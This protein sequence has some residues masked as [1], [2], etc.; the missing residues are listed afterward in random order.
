MDSIDALIAARVVKPSG[1]VSGEAAVWNGSGWDRSSVTRLGATS[2]GSGTP[3]ATKFLRGDGS[4]QVVSSGPTI[5]Y[6]TTP[7]GSPATGDIWIAVDSTTAPTYQWQFRWNGASTNADKWEFIGG[8]GK[9][10]R[11]D[12]SENTASGTDVDLTTVGP[13]F[14]LPRAGVYQ[15][16]WGFLAGLAGGGNATSTLYKGAASLTLSAITDTT[17]IGGALMSASRVTEVTGFAASDVLKMKYN[18]SNAVNT[19]FASRYM[20]VIPVRVS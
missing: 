8:I 15:I 11:V 14:T 17:T 9:T 7:P 6:A 4:W 12:T 5:T 18:I 1:I 2:L 13:S 3:D 19:S 16:E 20:R 10:V